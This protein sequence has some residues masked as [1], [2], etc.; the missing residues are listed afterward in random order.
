MPSLPIT[1]QNYP[2]ASPSV[3]SPLSV[4]WLE[5]IKFAVSCGAPIFAAAAT[6]LQ[7]PVAL[8][9]YK[10]I[11]LTCA[12]DV[13]SPQFAMAPGYRSLD[14]TEKANVSYWTGMT[15]AALVA[16]RAFG[17]TQVLH[18]AAYAGISRAFPSSRVLVDLVGEDTSGDWHVFEAKGR[19]RTSALDLTRWKSQARSISTIDGKSPTT[20]SV[21]ITNVG[22]E[23][24]VDLVDPPIA[25]Q[26]IS[27]EF[28][29]EAFA[30]RYYDPVVA[31]LSPQSLVVEDAERGIRARLAGFNPITSSFVW[32]G[33]TLE[34]LGASRRAGYRERG[35]QSGRLVVGTDGIVVLESTSSESPFDASADVKP[36]SAESS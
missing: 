2:A 26:S 34:L 13:G 28:S 5:L 21:C 33:A 16:Q 31:W 32:V 22:T 35:Y 1:L 7:A 23:Y 15:V 18:A 20:C 3:A 11:A 19:A 6:P 17:I 25:T 36:S 29:R 12:L 10:G 14:A 30:R 8:A 4:S 24:S 27:L 9:A